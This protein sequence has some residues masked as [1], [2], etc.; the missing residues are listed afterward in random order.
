MKHL[1]IFLVL[2][3]FFISE[4]QAC[5]V[6]C[7][8]CQPETN[9]CIDCLDINSSIDSFQRSCICNL[10]YYT[11]CLDPFQCLQLVN[12][13]SQGNMVALQAQT[14]HME[15]GLKTSLVKVNEVTDIIIINNIK[16]AQILVTL[17]LASISIPQ[18]C[19]EQY[20]TSLQIQDPN[21]LNYI[22]LGIQYSTTGLLGSQTIQ[23][24]LIDFDI[25]A[26]QKFNQGNQLSQIINFALNIGNSQKFYRNHKF[27]IT[28]CT[29]RAISTVMTT[30]IIQQVASMNCLQNE[31]CITI[32]NVNAN[33]EICQDQTCLQ[34]MQN[35]SYQVGQ[36]VYAKAQFIDPTSTKKLVLQNIY[37]KDDD[38]IIY[39]LTKFTNTSWAN[40][41]L[42][43]SFKIPSPSLHGIVQ[44]KMQIQNSR[45]RQLNSFQNNIVQQ[46]IGIEVVNSTI[47]QNQ[48]QQIID[49][50]NQDALSQ[51][52]YS[53]YNLFYLNYLL[54]LFL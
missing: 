11:G 1:T 10:G 49:Q 9:E 16:Y 38:S 43:I 34:P 54:L 35:P 44:I 27:S 30:D 40:K 3:I 31:Q 42:S 5:H 6:S 29:D 26:V 48:A 2:C 37:Y 28:L 13:D 23:I 36:M 8:N 52:N 18:D 22:D 53:S 19:Q 4:T 12:Y 51:V 20:V 15:M 39:D 47:S 7:A 21:S 17:D 45:L 41:I 46:Q 24:K 50:T 32:P 14:C 25:L 33:I